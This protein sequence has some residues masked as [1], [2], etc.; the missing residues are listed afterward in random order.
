MLPQVAARYP[1]LRQ[2]GDRRMPHRTAGHGRN[3]RD[4]L[5]IVREPASRRSVRQDGVAVLFRQLAIGDPRLSRRAFVQNCCKLMSGIETAQDREAM[6]SEEA[7][8]LLERIYSEDAEI[9]IDAERAFHAD[10]PARKP[11]FGNGVRVQLWWA[12]RCGQHPGSRHAGRSGV[13]AGRA[14]AQRRS[15]QVSRR[16]PGRRQ[17]WAWAFQS[18]ICAA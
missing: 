7:I 4:V 10:W 14:V 11:A 13:Q 17:G 3:Q 6:G 18:T 15:A 1:S 8:K 16:S 2:T 5:H 9:G 12:G